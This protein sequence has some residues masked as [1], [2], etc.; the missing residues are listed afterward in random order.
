M[1]CL[2]LVVACGRSRGSL[3]LHAFAL[4]TSSVSFAAELSII[5]YFCYFG[6]GNGDGL[7]S[8]FFSLPQL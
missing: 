2:T 1:M 6:N 4:A 8:I 7:G 5:L 3:F